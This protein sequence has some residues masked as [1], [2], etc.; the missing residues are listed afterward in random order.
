MARITEDIKEK[1]VTEWKLGKSQND[2]A[3]IYGVSKGT[4]NKL[5]KGVDRNLEQL[6]NK[7]VEINQS[8]TT[9]NDREMTAFR[10]DVDE[11]TRHLVFFSNSAINGQKLANDVLD[12]VTK[13]FSNS[14]GDKDKDEILGKAL[15]TAKEHSI[16]TKNNK[17]T[18]VGKEDNAPK[19]SQSSFVIRTVSSRD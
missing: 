17:E 1:I 18:V 11:K 5:C 15:A 9:L 13:R 7:Q 14:E 10:N 8:L 6:V 16:I 12:H 19:E 2:L 3:K 4:V